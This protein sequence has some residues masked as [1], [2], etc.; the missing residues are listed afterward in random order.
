[1]KFKK[2][3]LDEQLKQMEN[4]QNMNLVSSMFQI[5]GEVV[6]AFTGKEKEKGGK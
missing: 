6:G 5:P 3:M 1:M 4:A 2:Q